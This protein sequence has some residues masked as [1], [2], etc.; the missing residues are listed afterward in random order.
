MPAPEARL[1]IGNCDLRLVGTI[2]GFVPDAARVRA[3]FAEHKPDRVA[4]GIPPE[5]LDALKVLAAEPVPS[6]LIGRHQEPP[7]SRKRRMSDPGIGAAGLDSLSHPRRGEMPTQTGTDEA[8]IAGLDAASVR[9]L[10]LLGRFGPTAIPSPDLQSAYA[11]AQDAG[12]PVAAIDLD[13][14]A[15]A[16]SFTKLVKVRHLMRSNS[17]ERRLLAQ[18]FRGARD[19]YEL[20]QAWDEEQTTVKPLAAVE[21]L[22]EHHMAVQ[23]RELAARSSRLLAVVPAAR[24]AGVVADLGDTEPQG[25]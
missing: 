19:A 17:R 10:Q 25:I 20:V 8:P 14:A 16:E 6:R 11:A 15:H 18:E 1:R 7:P 24:F 3:A 2:A 9:L 22:R 23:L 13:D 21:R 5:D 12:T 4:L